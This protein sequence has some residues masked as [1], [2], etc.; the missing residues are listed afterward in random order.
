M[1]TLGLRRKSTT[2]TFQVVRSDYFLDHP[3][4]KALLEPAKLTPVSP[5]FIHGTVFVRQAHVLCVLLHRPLEEAL[6]A[7]TGPHP[8]VLTRSCVPAHGTQL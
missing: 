6:A 7:L 8:V 2:A 3:D 4:R 5:S 1:R